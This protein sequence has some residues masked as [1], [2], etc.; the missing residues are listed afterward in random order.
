M[1]I[2]IITGTVSGKIEIK[3]CDHK[4]KADAKVQKKKR[5]RKLYWLLAD[6]AISLIILGLVLYRPA[7]YQPVKVVYTRQVSTYLTNELLPQFY[8]GAQ[9]GEPFDVIVTQ[10]G[11]TD[12]VSRSRWPKES[13]GATFSAPVVLFVPGSVVLMGA[14]TIQGVEFV[15]TIELESSF[16][17]AGLMNLRASKVKVGAMNVTLLARIIAR[18]MYARR[19]AAVPID[20]EDWR[21]KIAASL[22]NDEAFEP[23]LNVRE[24]VVEGR[25]QKVRIE[26]ITI[27]QEKLTLRLIPVP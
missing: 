15:V 11:I 2:T 4:T 9:R 3:M 16:D 23:I 10:K 5:L 22:L 21:A 17:E 8:N 26:K 12:M 19:A 18:K 24:F 7:G 25:G 13:G 20:R 14:V 1:F 6:L 27:E